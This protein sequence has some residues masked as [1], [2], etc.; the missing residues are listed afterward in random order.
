MSNLANQLV[1]AE[2]EEVSRGIRTLLGGPLVTERAAPA[3]FDLVRRRQGP[4][5]RWFDYYCGWSVV[6]EPRQGYARLM[7]VRSDRHALVDDTRPARRL[8]SGRA[9]F[10]RRRYTLLCVVAAEVL[11]GP[12]TTI[13]LLADRVLQATRADPAL[14]VFDPTRRSERMAYVDVLRLLESYGAIESVDGATEA[15]VE[16]S[17]AKVLYRVD[18]TLVMRLLAAP[19][20]PSQLAVP[21]QEAPVRLGGLL[22]E[23]VHERRYGSS[24]DGVG[25][26]TAAP[27]SEVQRNLWLR[28]SVF[29]RI[30]DDP[31]VYREEL[32]EAQLAYLTSPTGRQLLRRAAEQAGFEVEERAE[33]YLLIDVDGLATDGKFPDDSSTAKV[34]ALALLDAIASAVGGL[35]DEELRNEAT[36][37]LRRAPRWALAYRSDDGADRLV[38]D[39]VNVLEQFG[40]VRRSGSLVFALPAASRYAVA[41]VN[42]V[43]DEGA[44]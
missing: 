32:S 29:R 17:E 38:S 6:V 25:D 16:S 24:T 14:A 10:D 15:Y 28:H 11:S 13:G 40:M 5:A 2:R 3:A 34:S 30:F 26:E 41:M 9:V 44:R 33:G 8:R 21:A 18:G 7:K 27:V 22:A 12:M 35:T 37:V 1:A 31:V 19:R 36:A 20:G 43:D 39:A 42:P 4:I 23:L